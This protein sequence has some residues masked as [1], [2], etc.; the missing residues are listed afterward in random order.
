MTARVASLYGLHAGSIWH[1]GNTSRRV[2][3]IVENPGNLLDEFALVPP[4]QL[5]APAQVTILLGPA[6]VQNQNQNEN[7]GPGPRA[8]QD[9]AETLPGLPKA[10]EAPAPAEAAAA[11]ATP[12][13]PVEP[14]VI[15]KGK[16]EEAA[17]EEK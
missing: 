11:A 2:T 1:Q 3:G 16:K 7:H 13:A 9:Q 15:K 5:T 12:A 4:G 14:E 17:E 6:A 8:G 10:E